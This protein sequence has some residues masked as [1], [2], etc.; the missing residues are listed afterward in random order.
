MIVA[1]VP[2]WVM[3]L[4]AYQVVHV[5]AVGDGLVPTVRSVLVVL[6]MGA[7]EPFRAPIGVLVAHLES[8]LVHVILVG[9][10]EVAVMKKIHVP[11]VQDGGMSA[12]GSVLMIVSV[13]R[14]VRHELS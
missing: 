13:V 3:Q 10:V 9:M 1:V 14:L 11:V 12:S 8:M 2:V 6:V 4:T 7:V 5:I